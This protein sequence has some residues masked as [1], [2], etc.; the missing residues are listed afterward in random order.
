MFFRLFYRSFFRKLI[1]TGS[2]FILRISERAGEDQDH[3]FSMVIFLVSFCIGG[4]GVCLFAFPGG[5]GQGRGVVWLL[6]NVKL[7]NGWIYQ[8]LVTY[9]GFS[10]CYFF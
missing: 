4:F 7:I 9:L 8:F 1:V 6:F 3:I 10:C 2:E 5:A